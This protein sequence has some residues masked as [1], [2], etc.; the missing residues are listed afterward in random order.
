[1]PGQQVEDLF[2]YKQPDLTL[3]KGERSYIVLF[4]MEAPY[5]DLYT[6]DQ[7]DST[8]NNVEYQPVP[9]GPGDVW[10]ELTFT[11]TSG[12]PFTTAV[13]TTMRDG[14]VIGQDTMHYVSP[15]AK[16]ELRITKALDI[17]AEAAEEEVTRQ[18]EALKRTPN[19]S[20]Y[21]EVTLKGTLAITNSKSQEVKLRIRK[22]FTG[23]LVSSDDN[24]ESTKTVKG[25]IQINPTGRL[26][27]NLTLKPGEK[28]KITYTYKLY[29]R[30]N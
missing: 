2:F 1:V 19:S 10:H 27:W 4:D 6:W 18:R 12:Q 28:R 25:L 21:D 7:V 23:E 24:P 15:K 26:V 22:D 11:N 13:A 5:Q 9:E 3:K 16:A 14:E 20:A 17:R 29:V 8:R 30:A